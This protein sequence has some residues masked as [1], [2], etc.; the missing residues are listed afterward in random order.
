MAGRV[1]SGEVAPGMEVL[2]GCSATFNISVPVHSVEFVD[3][4]SRK[5]EVGLTVLCEDEGELSI[6]E[7]LNVGE[8]EVVVRSVE[9]SGA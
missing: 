9:V 1:L 8:E 7:G 6:L 2:I 3:G 5:P 4:P